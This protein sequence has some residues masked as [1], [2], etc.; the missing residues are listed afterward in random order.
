MLSSNRCT[1]YFDKFD[2]W[3]VSEKVLFA[4]EHLCQRLVKATSIHG[5]ITVEQLVKTF[6]VKNT[7]AKIKVFIVLFLYWNRHTYIIVAPNISDYIHK[8]VNLFCCPKTCIDLFLLLLFFD[9]WWSVMGLMLI[10]IKFWVQVPSST[11]MWTT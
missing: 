3:S 11:H 10:Y 8:L 1:V 4:F 7:V 2:L 9:F 5:V 6:S